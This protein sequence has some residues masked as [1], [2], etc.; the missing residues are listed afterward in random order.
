MFEVAQWPPPYSLRYSRRAKNVQLRVHRSTGLE[1]IVPQRKKNYD[2]SALLLEK[3]SWI[4]K[5]WTTI[6]A[7]ANSSEPSV[8]PQTL[9][10]ELDQ[11]NWLIIYQAQSRS[12]LKLIANENLKLLTISGNLEFIHV[13]RI[14]ITWLKSYAYR[15]LLP[16]LQAISHSTGLCYNKFSIRSQ[17]TLWGSCNSARNINLNL[18]LIFLSMA[19]ID[20]VILHELCHTKY[21]NHGKR[22]WQLVSKYDP[23]YKIHERQLRGSDD[24]IPLWLV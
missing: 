7:A 12:R 4:I 2:P 14:L 11:T 10:I 19:L 13:K 23:D 21:L 22:F 16:R 18:K 17:Q 3:K 1:V 15:L 5:H 9:Q 20:Y 24:V 6:S 8:L